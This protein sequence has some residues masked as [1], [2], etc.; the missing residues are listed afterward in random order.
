MCSSNL[1]EKLLKSEAS[2][3]AIPVPSQA[4]AIKSN[5]LT[6]ETYSQLSYYFMQP[7]LGY[8]RV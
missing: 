1:F 2:K 5:Q 8:N 3:W 7:F 4:P 6:V